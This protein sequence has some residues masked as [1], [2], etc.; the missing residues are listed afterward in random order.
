M[1]PEIFKQKFGVRGF[2]NFWIISILNKSPMS[3]YQIMQSIKECTNN[4]WKPTPGAM[5][6]ALSK[7]KEMGWIEGK[8][9]GK[10]EQIIYSLTQK[11]KEIVNDMKEQFFEHSKNFKVRN[12]IDSLIWE[13]EPK[14]LKDKIEKFFV[15]I[16]D[17]RTSMNGKYK[18]ENLSKAIK[19][20][21][22]ITK[23]I[24]NFKTV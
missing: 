9:K 19:L 3:G 10:R 14:E 23:E 6:P 24:E 17:F 22:K 5:Y 12:I 15:A 11:G 4:V 20:I 16:L 2:L 8:K 18:K 1:R 13:N 21:E 7:L